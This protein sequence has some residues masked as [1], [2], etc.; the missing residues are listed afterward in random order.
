MKYINVL[1]KFGIA[2]VLGAMA[3]PS[4]AA[5]TITTTDL[6]KDIGT[7]QTTVITVGLAFMVIAFV[8][9]G[10]SAIRKS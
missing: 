9:R 8:V 6:I 1:K 3:Q 4:L 2:V 7:I 10:F 5:V